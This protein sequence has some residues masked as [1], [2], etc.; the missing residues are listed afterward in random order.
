MTVTAMAAVTAAAAAPGDAT[1]P[2]AP[3][4]PSHPLPL[5]AFCDSCQLGFAR[6]AELRFLLCQA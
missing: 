1:S 3:L 2:W 5:L 4:S 6:H